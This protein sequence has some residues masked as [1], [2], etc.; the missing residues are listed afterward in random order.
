MAE[1]K[2]GLIAGSDHLPLEL[3]RAARDAGRRVVGLAFRDLTDPS[4]EDEVEQLVWLHLGQ[5]DALVA[6]LRGAGLREVVM[7][8]KVPKLLLFE[9]SERV[10]PDARALQM[11][12]GLGDRADDAILQAI[13]G[14][15]EQQGIRV[16]PQAELAPRLLAEVGILGHIHP[17][18]TQLGEI[19]FAW[20]LAKA[21]AGLDIGQTVVVRERAVLAVEAIDGTDATI[22]RGGDLA[23]GS[24]C[25]V[26][27][28]KP[29]QDPRF[30]L[31]A[32]GLGTVE[33][34]AAAEV[35]VMA[36]EAG[37]TLVLERAALIE[38]A[39]A[40]GIALVG[41]EPAGPQGLR[42]RPI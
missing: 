32:I 7:A 15:I 8:G 29:Q 30:D 18:S 42:E 4:L 40:H 26:K 2:L 24:A 34:L 5:L 33:S 35:P 21:L 25:V 37:R 31:P 27:V 38:R 39:D 22:R 19:A 41:I 17:T 11:V 28:A 36:V 13:V 1:P 6:A 20:P 3:A 10:R 16:L 14:L 23:R 12:E 9:R